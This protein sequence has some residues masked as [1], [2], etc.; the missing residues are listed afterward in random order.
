MNMR[1]SGS[2]KYFTVQA[3]R[4]G[5]TTAVFMLLFMTTTL[6]CQADSVLPEIPVVSVK[7]GCFDMGDTFGDGGRDEKPAHQVCVNDYQIGKFE[8]TQEQWQAVMGSNPSKTKLSGQHPVDNVSW[9]DTQEFIQQLNKMSGKKWRLPTEA[10][11]EYA[12]RSGGMKQR[13]AGTNSMENLAD[14][15][16]YENNS[17]M[18][19]HPVGTRQSNGL[20]LYDMSGNVW[21]W[22]ADRYDRNYYKQSPLNNPKGDPFGINRILRGGSAS[23]KS[24]FQ[25]ASY[26]DYVAPTVRGD[27][28][29]LRMVLEIK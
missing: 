9:N 23:S 5:F 4:Y 26:R 13:F 7:G 12:A 28:F 24:G 29:S 14:Y 17:E 22:C 18:T 19:T 11:W 16:W 20:G 21:E 27:L 2:R 15:A 6:P 10:E 3:W 1:C 8:V 25:R